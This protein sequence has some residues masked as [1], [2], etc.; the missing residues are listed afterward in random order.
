M[1]HKQV[2]STLNSL[3]SVMLALLHL[4]HMALGHQVHYAQ[5]NK[6]QVVLLVQRLCDCFVVLS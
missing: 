3:I 6:M 2:R 1:S 4:E 5:M